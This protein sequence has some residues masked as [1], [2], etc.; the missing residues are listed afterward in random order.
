M[1]GQTTR[2][3]LSTS[4]QNFSFLIRE[5]GAGGGGYGG[6][7]PPPPLNNFEKFKF[8]QKSPVRSTHHV[9]TPVVNGVI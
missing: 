2:K 6:F 3:K 9:A 5:R 8:K 7:S 4:L 1:F